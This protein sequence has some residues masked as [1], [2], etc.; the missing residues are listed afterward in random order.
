M[1]VVV[2][3][4]LLFPLAGTL[5]ACPFCDG[6]ESG[7]NEVKEEVFGENFWPHILATGM[8]FAVLL[9]VTVFLHFGLGSWGE[10][11]LNQGE[12]K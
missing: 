7:V 2:M 6:G 11:P 3:A 9:G 10:T 5:L 1:V 12:G 4:A 8:T